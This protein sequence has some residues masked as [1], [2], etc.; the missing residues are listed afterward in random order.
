M[1]HGRTLISMNRTT[2]PLLGVDSLRVPTAPPSARLTVRL[3]SA[4]HPHPPTE[5][6]VDFFQVGFKIHVC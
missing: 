1:K 4:E 2:S 6:L 5:L 3:V